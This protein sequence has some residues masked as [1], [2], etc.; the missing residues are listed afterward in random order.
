MVNKIINASISF[1]LSVP[2]TKSAKLLISGLL[3]KDSNNRIEI[4]DPLFEEWF[5][6][7]SL[8]EVCVKE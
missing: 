4:N 3:E 6:D 7:D 5:K 8:P 2:I 1:P